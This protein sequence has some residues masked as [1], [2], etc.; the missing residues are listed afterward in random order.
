MSAEIAVV[1]TWDEFRE[2]W[3]SRKNFILR[4][5]VFAPQY[6][7]P[8]LPRVI[9]EVRRHENSRMLHNQ[10][11]GATVKGPYPEFL[12]MPLDDATQAEA[13][14][15]HFD[16]AEFAGPGQVFEGMNQ[17][18]DAWYGGLREHGFAWTG[19]QC[20]F[21]LSGPNTHTG[22]HFDSSYVLVWQ[23]HGI[24]RFCWL[25]EPERW[26]PREV[27]REYADKYER[28]FR[29]EGITP[30]DVIEFEMHPG[31][32]L[33]NVMLTPHWVYSLDEMTWSI[34]ITHF[35]LSC[36]GRLSGVNKEWHEDKPWA[37]GDYRQKLAAVGA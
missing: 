16:A 29:P 12:E 21:F 34:N 15:A 7:A 9:E 1:T 33:W 26:C 8:P 23:V 18:F 10:V 14:L 2:Q 27:R 32:I 25:K 6:T 28:M 35:N 3:D 22:Y 30:D 24:K 31:D 5:E 4:G 37:A 19:T 36:D 20:A 13:L 17:V 11:I